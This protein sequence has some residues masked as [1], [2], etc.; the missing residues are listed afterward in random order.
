MLKL[1]VR[2]VIHQTKRLVLLKQCIW[3]DQFF[4]ENEMEFYSFFPFVAHF[5]VEQANQAQMAHEKLNLS[6]MPSEVLEHILIYLDNK[7]LLKASHVCK[8]FASVAETVFVRKYSKELYLARRSEEALLNK[9]G[10]VLRSIEVCEGDEKILDLI[11]RKCHSLE[12]A[13]LI[14][15][16]KMIQLKNLKEAFLRDVKNLNRRMF[17]EFIN[18]NRQLEVFL[19]ED[20]DLNLVDLMDDRLNSLKTFKYERDTELTINLPKIRLNSLETLKLRPFKNGPYVRLLQALEC[21]QLKELILRHYEGSDDSDEVTNAICSFKTLVW[22]RMPQFPVSA[23]QLQKLATHL[24]HLTKL[25]IRIAEIESNQILNNMMS[26]LWILPKL[27][28]LTIHLNDNGNFG[29]FLSDLKKS[30]NEFHACFAHKNTEIVIDSD[31]GIVCILNE[32]VSLSQLGS[33]ELHWMANLN[34]KSV[35]NVMYGLQYYTSDLKFINHCEDT[36]DICGFLTEYDHL[37]ILD[38][39]SNGPV[40]FKANVSKI[41]DLEFCMPI[42]RK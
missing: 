9:Y 33:L 11:E 36:L 18:N 14:W 29:I 19:L 20:N 32:C 15:I 10:G 28:K 25:S 1:M 22:L 13:R 39:K 35:R 38:I 27:S 23:I 37:E 16:P 8:K 17:N 26:V 4:N 21:N 42:C 40:T 41:V 30:I 7:N 5:T 3:F 24:P 31:D 6:R 34:E 12:R 2:Q